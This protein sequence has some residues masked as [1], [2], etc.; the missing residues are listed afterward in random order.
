MS[1]GL[2]EI[3][4]MNYDSAD[5]AIFH[6]TRD[7]HW[8]DFLRFDE[9]IEAGKKSAK[10]KLPEIKRM[11]RRKSPWY[12]KMSFRFLTR[13]STALAARDEINHNEI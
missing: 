1:Q 7:I 8:S 5:V 6:D 10:E 12:K 3:K 2:N 4:F 13:D 11:I 9:L